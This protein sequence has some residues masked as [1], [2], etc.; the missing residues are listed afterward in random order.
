MRQTSQTTLVDPAI[1]RPKVYYNEGPFDAPSSSDE[2]AESLLGD[3]NHE[4]VPLSP[5]MAELGGT[6]PR[7]AGGRKGKSN[8]VRLPLTYTW[9]VLIVV[10][11]TSLRCLI[12]G[13][14]VLV[15]MAC[16]I[17]VFAAMGYSVPE[18]HPRSQKFT[19]DHI[20]NGTFS[21]ER[22]SLHWVPEAGDGVFSIVQGDTIKLVDLKTQQSQDLVTVKDI[23]NVRVFTHSSV[24]R[25]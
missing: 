22:T 5:G 9:G 11:S 18:L 4:E 6:S 14:V 16:L 2:E 13:I 25:Y 7:S 12:L 3:G 1:I 20:F 23:R 24:R 17:G 8:T 21:P 19:M 10:Q 15:G